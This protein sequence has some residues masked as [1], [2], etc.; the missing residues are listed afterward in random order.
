MDDQFSAPN[1]LAIH[2][3]LRLPEWGARSIDLLLTTL[4][5]NLE[6]VIQKLLIFFSYSL[7][8][9]R[10]NPLGEYLSISHDTNR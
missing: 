9:S 4:A 10:R 8:D 7:R 1:G 2:F 3:K 6:K 5:L